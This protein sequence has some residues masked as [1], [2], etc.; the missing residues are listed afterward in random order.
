MV[1]LRL[2]Y[3]REQQHLPLVGLRVFLC[4]FQKPT[5]EVIFVP[6]GEGDQYGAVLLLPGV[7]GGGVPFPQLVPVCGAV[8]FLPVLDG[9]IDYDVIAAHAGDAAAHAGPAVAAPVSD[10]LENVRVP[11]GVAGRCPEALSVQAGL[12][13]QFEVQLTVHYPLNVP[14]HPLGE[15]CAVG[16]GDDV[17][18]RVAPE[19]MGRLRAGAA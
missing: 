1:A 17:R 14:V 7:E 2:R 8:R 18:V 19:E 9:V 4:R 6:A 15:V 5:G 12:R 11:Q 10:Y 13:E 3:C 16:C